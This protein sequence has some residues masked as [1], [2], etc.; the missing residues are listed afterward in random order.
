M[1]EPG[2]KNDV[3]IGVAGFQLPGQL[4]PADVRHL[5]IQKGHI[6]AV[7]LQKGQRVLR[8]EKAVQLRPRRGLLDG[9]HQTIQC[10]FFIVHRNDSHTLPPL[11]IRISAVVP[12]PGALVTVSVPPT[13]SRR[14]SRT[15][16]SPKCGLPSSP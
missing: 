5:H 2:G 16:R 13:I 10:Q 8:V 1:A 15:L 7:A 6:A 3:H 4:H 14:R 12:C 11:G 9:R